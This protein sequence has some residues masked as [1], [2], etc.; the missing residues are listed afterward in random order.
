MKYLLIIFFAVPAL[1]SEWSPYARIGAG[2]K[3]QERLDLDHYYF[4]AP[5]HQSDYV[6]YDPGS[7]VSALFEAG[8]K[9]KQFTF[10][11]KHDSQW[12]DG[13]PFNESKEYSKSEIFVGF[14]FGR[15]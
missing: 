2:Y 9:Y 12:T 1:S 5:K 8:Y 3:F 15:N 6:E 14:T 10:A 11:I 13:A 7:K 4:Y